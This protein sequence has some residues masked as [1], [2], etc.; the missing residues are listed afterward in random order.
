MEDGS[1][2]TPMRLGVLIDSTTTRR[3]TTGTHEQQRDWERERDSRS[4]SGLPEALPWP[5]NPG[6]EYVRRP[7]V[8][9]QFVWLQQS[10]AD[11]QQIALGRLHRARKKTTTCSSHR[12]SNSRPLAFC[13]VAASSIHLDPHRIPISSHAIIARYLGRAN[14][15]IGY[16][17]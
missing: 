4:D 16:R 7:I 2:S 12:A 15:D 10:R 17:T 1:P 6:D 9:I 11:P 3:R 13:L 8:S 5:T 14:S